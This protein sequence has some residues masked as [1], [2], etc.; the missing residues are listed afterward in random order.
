MGGAIVL[1]EGDKGILINIAKV[2]VVLVVIAISLMFV[3]GSI[4]GS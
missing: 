3:A 4:G 1:Q 2:I